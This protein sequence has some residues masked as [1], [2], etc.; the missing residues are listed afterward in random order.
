MPD[1]PPPWGRGQ[2][3]GGDSVRESKHAKP[4]C[5]GGLRFDGVEHP[6]IRIVMHGAVE[7]D[8]EAM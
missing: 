7:F 6:S 8:R 4:P 3:W 2:G 5:F 1:S